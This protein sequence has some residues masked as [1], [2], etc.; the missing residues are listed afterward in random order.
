MSR[1]H[2]WSDGYVVAVADQ[3]C[4][5]YQTIWQRFTAVDPG[6]ADQHIRDLLAK[7][8]AAG[9]PIDADMPATLPAG[10]AVADVVAELYQW[11]ARVRQVG[12]GIFT[13]PDALP[14][15]IFCTCAFP[16]EYRGIPAA[17]LVAPAE[18]ELLHM[19]DLPPHVPDWQRRG[20]IVQFSRLRSLT[21]FNSALG[22]QPLGIA[23]GRLPA[24]QA[25]DLRE[26]R[27]TA[28]PAEVL[29]CRKLA[30]LALDD[31][32]LTALPNLLPLRQL[33]YLGLRRTSLTPDQIA[34]ARAQLPAC[35]VVS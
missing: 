29:R 21:L 34:A 5:N 19:G 26:N 33:R 22:G 2:P 27:L 11:V 23:L 9:N 28:L 16:R 13:Q 10:A 3:I 15:Q 6:L 35:L 18:V 20:A 31:N 1:P 8:R 7:V 25:L 4:W 12:S 14:D 30:F 17:D 24:L 32:P